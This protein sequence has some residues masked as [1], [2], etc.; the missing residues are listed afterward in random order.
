MAEGGGP[1]EKKEAAF[2]TIN[3]TCSL[4]RELGSFVKENTHNLLSGVYMVPCNT[5]LINQSSSLCPDTLS[6]QIN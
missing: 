5:L 6:Y 2:V 3:I 1:E 4:R